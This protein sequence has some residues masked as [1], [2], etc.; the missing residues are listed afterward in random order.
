MLDTL[1]NRL[2]DINPSEDNPFAEDKLNRSQYAYSLCNIINAYSDTGCVISI[3]GEWGTG[4]TTFV[5]MWQKHLQSINYRT[6]YFNAWKTDY[7]SDPLVALLGELKELIGDNEKFKNI[8][9]VI[10]DISVAIG[11]SFVK[12]STKVDVDDIADVIN[13]QIKEYTK[14]RTTF[15][16]FKKL[17]EEYV[18]SVN[19]DQ[20]VPVI[21]II[22][23]LDRCNPHFAVK[24]L[25]RVK[26]LFDIPNIIFVL[27]I[28]KKQLEY[29]IQ[30]FYG[31]DKIDA[32]NYLRRF[33]DLEFELPKPNHEQFFMFLY[34]HHGFDAYFQ[35]KCPFPSDVTNTRELFKNLVVKLC[36]QVDVDLRT[37]DKLFVHCR[38]VATGIHGS[39]TKQ[40]DLI[41]LLCFI[42]IF[43]Y[44]LY[45]DI[46]QHNLSLQELVTR[47]E[48]TFPHQLLKTDDTFSN[49]YHT[50]LYVLGELLLSYNMYRRNLLEKDVFPCDDND[51]KLNLDLKVIDEK[52][53]KDGINYAINNN[54]AWDEIKEITD[55]IDL[56]KIK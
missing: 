46:R 47:F 56:I 13:D 7:V 45:C 14:Q 18:A 17:L 4:K 16:K 25:E 36:S 43:Y 41:F 6:I 40:M 34:D 19:E 50:F 38:L 52:K 26:H 37:M 53:L 9:G 8:L 51:N 28:S 39:R 44:D 22:D 1:S 15:N 24:V 11:K 32:A 31:S 20:P 10:G 33:I 23:E 3:N 54:L 12:N 21:F 42:K 49:D 27:P 2:P 30:G 29:S 48:E 35:K 55:K 5:K